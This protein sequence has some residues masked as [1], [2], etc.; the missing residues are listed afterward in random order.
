MHRREDC[1]DLAAGPHRAHRSAKDEC[2]GLFPDSGVNDDTGHWVRE[3]VEAQ[4]HA[5]AES[6]EEDVAAHTAL[7]SFHR[8]I[9]RAG[10]LVAALGEDVD[11]NLPDSCW[12]DECEGR[13]LLC[14]PTI[15]TP[16]V[17]AR[18]W[19]LQLALIP[20]WTSTRNRGDTYRWRR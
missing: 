8:P 9:G 6:P 18:W 1:R 17:R 2:A 11:E 16:L 5:L 19:P 4:V 13:P 7:D 12:L 10:R 14:H 15:Y 20:R 3:E